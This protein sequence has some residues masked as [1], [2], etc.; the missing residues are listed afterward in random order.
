MNKTAASIIYRMRLSFS[1]Q[2]LFTRLWPNSTIRTSWPTCC[3]TSPTNLLGSGKTS[4]QQ[5]VQ[6]VGRWCARH[7]LV[8]QQVTT[9]VWPLVNFLILPVFLYASKKFLNYW[10]F[11]YLL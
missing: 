10:L 2:Q 9:G 5:V 7:E 3:A 11:I 8:G 6:V 4:A 1:I